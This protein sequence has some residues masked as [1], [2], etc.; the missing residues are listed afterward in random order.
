M[1]RPHHL[2]R[3]FDDKGV[4]LYVGMSFS[5]F[6]RA[7]QHRLGSFWFEAAKNMTIEAFPSRRDAVAA[8]RKAIATENPKFNTDGVAA[9]GKRFLLTDANVRKLK[10]KGFYTDTE[11]PGL[12][13]RV[14]ANGCR[15]Y[16]YQRRI[17]RR[18]V[19]ITILKS[20]G[21]RV[22]DARDVARACNDIRNQGLDPQVERKINSEVWK[23]AIRKYEQDFIARHAA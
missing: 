17:K 16:V 9:L 10:R 15:S 23:T 3:Y 19:T 4:L 11:V 22:D 2:Y 5:A 12:A 20:D 1:S 6:A 18:L 21:L 13:V 8:E 7:A 14:T